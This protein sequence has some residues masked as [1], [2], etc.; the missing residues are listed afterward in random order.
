MIEILGGGSLNGSRPLSIGGFFV[1]GFFDDLVLVVFDGGFFVGGFLDDLILVVL[2]GGLFD[3]LI[4]LVLFEGLILVVF[5]LS[6]VGAAV[7]GKGVIT[8][9]VGKSGVT[10]AL[11]VGV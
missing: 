2:D 3:V 4:F 10:P 7:V 8:T 1:A 11:S 9:A 6:V 5:G